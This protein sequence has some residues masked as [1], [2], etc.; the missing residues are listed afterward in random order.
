MQRKRVLPIWLRLIAALCLTLAL[1]GQSLAVQA[2]IIQERNNAE[3]RQ[4]LRE[5]INQS[6]SFTDRF[7]AEVWLMDMSGRLKKKITDPKE[8]LKFLRHV[9]YEATRANL[10]PELVLAVIEVESNFNRWAIS[11]AGAQGL[12]QVMPFW[13]D[14][15]GRPGDNLFNVQTNL[16]LGCTILRYYLDKE[17]GNLGRALGRYNGSL[18]QWKYPNKI[19]AALQKRWF[20]Q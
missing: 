17:K 1:P 15:I 12:M 6:D 10:T 4:L 3:L 14:E 16:R 7:D 5:A 9:H 20:K 18:G 19:F 8:R 2:S 11:V 13:L